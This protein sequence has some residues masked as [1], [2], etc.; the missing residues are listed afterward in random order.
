M[1]DV[2]EH[3][4]LEFGDLQSAVEGNAA[5]LRSV[6]DYQPVGGQ[7][8]KVFPP[9]YEGGKY[10]FEK[11]RLPGE[12]EPVD[13]VLLDSV[14]S[15]A[16]RMEEALLD[17]WESGEIKLPVIVVDFQ[18]E[19]LPRSLRVTS[20]DAPHRIADAL[21]RDSLLKDVAF[22]QSDIGKQIDFVD[23]RNATPLF[24]YCPT[25]L[26][27]G[28]W[29]STGPRGGLGAK[30]ARALVSE[31]IGLHAQ[32]GVKVSSRID[33]AEIRAGAGTVYRADDEQGIAWTLDEKEA[34]REKKENKDD[35]PLKYGKGQKSG[36]PSAT[37]H[38][39]V[40]P[41]FVWERDSNNN[42]VSYKNKPS[43]DNEVM[44]QMPDGK[45]R[46]IAGAALPSA[47]LCRLQF[48]R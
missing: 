6:T 39:N 45:W 9:T 27:F 20:L 29:D 24:E 2:S 14:Q 47:K 13:C 1:N 19:D 38:G 25:A 17:T 23:V 8:D 44:I 21:L 26:V 32:Q 10:A 3:K 35:E 12:E 48:S 5:A 31:M 43:Q 28:M 36:K 4:T 22:R 11:R 30:F 34:K 7:G 41:D 37:N 46:R 42:I 15:Q 18:G 33:P 16:N 40:T